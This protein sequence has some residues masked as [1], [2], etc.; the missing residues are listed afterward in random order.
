MFQ[1]S[2]DINQMD[3]DGIMV[4]GRS[5]DIYPMAATK[6]EYSCKIS[7][8]QPGISYANNNLSKV[9]IE[10]KEFLISDIDATDSSKPF[11][12]TA[13]SAGEDP[14]SVLLNTQYELPMNPGTTFYVLTRVK[15]GTNNETFDKFRSRVA[16]AF[17]VRPW[18]GNRA[19]LKDQALKFGGLGPMLISLKKTGSGAIIT[20]FLATADDEPA[21]LEICKRFH[22][23]LVDTLPLTVEKVDVQPI[24]HMKDKEWVCQCRTTA[25]ILSPEDEVRKALKE[26]AHDINKLI[27]D[28][29]LKRVDL[30]LAGSYVVHKLFPNVTNISI[31]IDGKSEYDLTE[32]QICTVDKVTIQPVP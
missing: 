32:N 18:G 6:T 25:A 11:K 24:G 19:W 22:N 16:D 26:F 4:F 27:V 31:T 1:R 8:P 13:V 3:E 29:G 30:N 14:N 20:I 9:E 15:I 10:D 5:L 2:L 28:V 21:S 23:E 7:D 12:I 17:K